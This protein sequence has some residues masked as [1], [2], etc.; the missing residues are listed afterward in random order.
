M[1]RTT[2]NKQYIEQHKNLGRVRAV[3]HLY[4]FY[5]C[6]EKGVGLFFLRVVSAVCIGQKRNSDQS[7]AVRN[8]RKDNIRGSWVDKEG[9][10]P[11]VGVQNCGNIHM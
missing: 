3:P 10:I 9:D 2:Q 5:P 1:H 11:G 6:L 7:I 4:G 8:R